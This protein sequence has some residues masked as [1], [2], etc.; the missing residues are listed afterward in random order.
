MNECDGWGK[1]KDCELRS[2]SDNA[3]RKSFALVLVVNLPRWCVFFM[4]FRGRGRSSSLPLVV[5]TSHPVDSTGQNVQY[6]NSTV[7]Y[8]TEGFPWNLSFTKIRTLS[9]C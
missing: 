1:P 9:H 4:L 3:E 6:S 7:S 5:S 8:A 2:L